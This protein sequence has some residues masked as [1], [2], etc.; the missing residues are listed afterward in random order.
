MSVLTTAE[1]PGSFEFWQVVPIFVEGRDCASSV[2]DIG[3]FVDI[4]S[5]AEE[6]IWELA[7]FLSTLS[8]FPRILSAYNLRNTGSGKLGEA[9]I[10]APV[11][12]WCKTDADQ[13]K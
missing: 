1:D 10:F 12:L 8:E 6:E 13:F 3:K 5:T 2:A 7:S 11:S 9:L 4:S